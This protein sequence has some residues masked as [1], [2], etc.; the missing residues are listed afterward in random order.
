MF[1]HRA[2]RVPICGDDVAAK[3]TVSRLV[4]ALGCV[5]LDIGPLHRARHL[6]AMAAI[7]IGLLF[8]GAD[9]VAVFNLVDAQAGR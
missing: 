9:P 6:E 2:L 7:V 4:D 1:D 3:A 5:P 8:D